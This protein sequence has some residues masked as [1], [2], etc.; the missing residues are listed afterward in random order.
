[1]AASSVDLYLSGHDH[2]RQWLSKV[3]HCPGVQFVV[4]GAGAKTKALGGNNP[5]EFEDASIGGF[6]Y[7][8]IAGPTLTAEFID[9]N[10]VV[11]FSTTLQ[12]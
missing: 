4:S 7:V 8:H 12:K 6:L 3:A 10:G 1:M 11:N 9:Q 2:N 5:T